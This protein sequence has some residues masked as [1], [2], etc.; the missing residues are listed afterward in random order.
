MM[1]ASGR[2]RFPNA[3]ERERE[4]GEPRN[5]GGSFEMKSRLHSLKSSAELLVEI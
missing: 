1:R 4:I 5:A 3:E 2:S